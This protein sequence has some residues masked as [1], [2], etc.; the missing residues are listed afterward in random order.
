MSLVTVT[1]AVMMYGWMQGREGKVKWSGWSVNLTVVIIVLVPGTGAGAVGLCSCT[2][3]CTCTD[4]GVSG[5]GYDG[6]VGRV[7]GL[8]WE[9]SV[10]F[11][12]SWMGIVKRK[13]E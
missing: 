12:Q 3:T 6:K 8:E 2:Y 9:G 1:V 4:C 11:S 10:L 13:V 7:G 5:C